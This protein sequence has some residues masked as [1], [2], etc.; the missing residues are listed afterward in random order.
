MKKP[1]AVLLALA[2]AGCSLITL[3]FTPR[4]RPL[5]EQTVEVAGRA[6]ILLVDVSGFLSKEG[7]SPGLVIG[8]AP[9]RVPL[10]VRLRAGPTKAAADADGRALVAPSNSPGGPVSAAADVGR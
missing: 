3:D 6:K 8:A 5:E 9:P 7:G 1:L 2:L 4:I 10:L